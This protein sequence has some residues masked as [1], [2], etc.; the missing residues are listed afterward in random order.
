MRTATR[1]TGTIAVGLAIAALAGTVAYAKLP[2]VTLGELAIDAEFIGVVR[3]DRVRRG[4]PLFGRRR[5]T[6]TILQSWK[7]P[8]HGDVTFVASS[9]WT[10]DISDALEEEEAV[11]FI[12]D[13]VLLH[14]GRGRMPVFTRDGQR[15]AAFW[16]E[17]RLPSSLLPE[18]GPQSEGEY[19]HAVPV[20]GLREA[21]AI[22][23][24]EEGAP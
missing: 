18:A 13:G 8:S 3:V 6:A 17:V 11:V 12:R 1:R 24:Q 22:A 23:L 9:S 15:L 7:G 14:G 20:G 5:A 10:C 16:P 19:V 4:F 21:V 2:P